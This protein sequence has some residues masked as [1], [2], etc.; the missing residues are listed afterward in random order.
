VLA[1]SVYSYIILVHLDSFGPELVPR[2]LPGPSSDRN[3]TTVARLQQ[4]SRGLGMIVLAGRGRISYYE[5]ARVSL[6]LRRI[7]C[8]VVQLVRPG[9]GSLARCFQV[10]I[11]KM[12][13]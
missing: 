5:T 11:V 13:H 6:K 4:P 9:P 7:P 1:P 8:H 3:A 2:C 12:L 10:Y